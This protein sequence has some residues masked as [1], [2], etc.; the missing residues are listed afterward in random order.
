MWPYPCIASQVD[1]YKSKTTRQRYQAALASLAFDGINTDESWVFHSTAHDNIIKIMCGGLCVGGEGGVAIKNGA[2]YGNGVYAATGPATPMTYSTGRGTNQAVIL[3][4]ALHGRAGTRIGQGNSW[5]A[6]W[7][8]WVFAD[9][10][11]LLPVYVVH[12]VK[13]S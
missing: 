11:Q 10:A 8:W 6:K 4:R 3:A 9:S 12:I 2:T 7:D 13:P 1:V 5:P